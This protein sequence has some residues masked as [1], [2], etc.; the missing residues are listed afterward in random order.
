MFD[1]WMVTLP[2]VDEVQQQ[3][4]KDRDIAAGP[5]CQIKVG[6]IASRRSP[7]VDDDDAGPA[8]RSGGGKTLV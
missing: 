1:P 7:R 8:C 2:A 4:G 3:S 5:Q 6:N